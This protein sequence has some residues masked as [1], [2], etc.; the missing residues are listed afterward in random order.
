MWR[1]LLAGTAALLTGVGVAAA[2]AF[3]VLVLAGPHADT[4]PTVL[5]GAVRVLAASAV[6]VA[7]IAV[8][9]AVW[10]RSAPRGGADRDRAR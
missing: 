2:M 7:P 8:A 3:A 5:Q 9:R 1:I 6:I 4:L 10:R